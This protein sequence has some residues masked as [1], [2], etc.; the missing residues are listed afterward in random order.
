MCCGA[1]T[2]NG[3][4]HHFLQRVG[5]Q[6]VSNIVVWQWMTVQEQWNVS[7]GRI[8]MAAGNVSI[9]FCHKC[10]IIRHLVRVLSK[11]KQILTFLLVFGSDHA[12][13]PEVIALEKELFD[14]WN[15]IQQR[16]ACKHLRKGDLVTVQGKVRD[17]RGCRQIICQNISGFVST[18]VTHPKKLRSAVSPFIR[19][20]CCQFFSRK[21]RLEL[22]TFS[23]RAVG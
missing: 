9:Y 12:D 20:S 17:F 11:N 2:G 4:R 22:R 7:C 6:C 21:R 10:Q 13:A 14:K 23:P 15:E 5:I 8:N 19:S 3:W 1:T 16:S 18:C